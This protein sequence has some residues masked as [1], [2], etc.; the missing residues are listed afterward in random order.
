MIKLPINADLEA[1]SGLS[2]A[3]ILFLILILLILSK[4]VL[5]MIKKQ[6]ELMKKQEQPD[7]RKN[8]R[9][10]STLPVKDKI[11]NREKMREGRNQP[12]EE[13]REG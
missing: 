13:S 1:E 4:D 8:K 6:Q 3:Y 12:K 11:K 10:Y 2:T 5:V 7:K 9:V